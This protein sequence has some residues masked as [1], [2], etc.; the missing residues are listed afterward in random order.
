[1][2][3]TIHCDDCHDTFVVIAGPTKACPECGSSNVETESSPTLNKFM[4]STTRRLMSHPESDCVFEIFTEE[5]FKSASEAGCDEVTGVH[6][7]EMRFAEQK[8]N[9]DYE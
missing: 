3:V 5:Q 6:D 1:M 9:E 2:G 8:A 7:W 4:V